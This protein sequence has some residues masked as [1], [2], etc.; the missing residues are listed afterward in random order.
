MLS[1]AH[2][3]EART[4]DYDVVVIGAGFAGLYMLHSLR[5]HGLKVRVLE[6][7]DGVGGTWFWNRYP[8]ARCDIESL[9]YQYSFSERIL[10][11]WKWSE[12]Y[13]QQPEILAYLNFVADT[14]DLRGDIE[15]G[16][17][18]VGASFLDDRWAVDTTAGRLS[19]RFLVAATGN[20]SVPQEPAIEGLDIFSGPIYHTARWP[21][22]SVN[23]SG[24]KVVVIG[25]GSSGIQVI[26][27]L[28]EQADEL[29]VL[30]RTPNYSVPA[31]SGDTEQA[32]ELADYAGRRKFAR[33]S[34]LGL[35]YPSNEKSALDVTEEERIEEYERRWDLGGLSIYGA[36]ADLMSD[37]KA[38]RT[39]ADF[40]EQKIRAKVDD[41]SV[42]D[43]L[44]PKGI[45]VGG[46]RVCT[47][48]RYYE[49][50]NRPNVRLVDVRANP[51]ERL[52]ST[53]VLVSG[54]EYRADV[55]VMATGFKAMTGALLAIDIRG[56][57][58][59]ALR[60]KWESG[61]R[62]YLGVAT[63]GFPNLFFVTGPGSPSVFSNVVI[64]IEQHVE[65]ISATIAHLYAEKLSAIEPTAEAEAEWVEHVN[66]VAYSTL[67][68][69]ASSWYMG[70]E[71]TEGRRVFMPYLGGVGAYREKCDQVARDNYAGFTLS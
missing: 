65:W 48:S 10:A 6:A 31:R 12:R 57:D 66:D 26:P 9:D 14:L 47:D 1:T 38:N 63:A 3:H 56:R 44:V 28:A 19:T 32:S 46:K 61:P 45:P 8:G 21:E 29:T 37:E 20:L 30:Q 40:F 41:P 53:G 50:F 42:A 15:L 2:L 33:E 69:Q 18:V 71:V 36:F 35:A 5:T 22:E 43:I 54:R 64:S 59:Q 27:I 60:Q 11:E 13:P 52:T 49:T 17:R 4:T 67:L 68:P 70:P 7:G 16:V 25:T 39:A 34:A 55:I 24:K 58:G 62:T 51:I 23:L